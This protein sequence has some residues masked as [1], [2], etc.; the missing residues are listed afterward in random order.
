MEG[1]NPSVRVVRHWHR[2]PRGAMDFSSPGSVQDQVG[3][4][5]G[6]PSGRGPFPWQGGWNWMVFRVPSNPSHSVIL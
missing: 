1:R 2:L 5:F 6:Q 3:W 4:V